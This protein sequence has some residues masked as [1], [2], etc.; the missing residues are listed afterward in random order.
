MEYIYN[1]L[2]IKL[3]LFYVETQVL[4]KLQSCHPD[5]LK[6]HFHVFLL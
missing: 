2:N 3:I 4:R 5:K 6:I 1:N